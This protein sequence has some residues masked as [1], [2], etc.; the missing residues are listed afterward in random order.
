M[1]TAA[2]YASAD[3]Y[4]GRNLDLEY[5]YRETVTVTPRNYPFLFRSAASLNRH[6]A[7]IGMAFVV[8]EY[9][10][11]Y[12]ATN[13]KGL[14][15][16]GLNFPGNAHYGERRDGW[17]NIAPFEFI[18]WVLGQC[19]SL[20]EARR[21]LEQVNLVQIHFSEQ[22]PL[23][24]LHWMIADQR[25]AI[26]VEPMRDGLKV[27]DNPVG[28]LTNNPPFDYQMFNLNNYMQLTREPP[29]NRF[30]DGLE[31]TQYC[32]GM[33]AMGLPGDLSSASRFVRAAFTRMNSVSGPTESESVSQ[34]FHILGSVEQQ[35]GCSH[36]GGDK[37]EITVYSSCCNVD[38]GIYYYKTYENSQIAAVDMHRE[39]L[40]GEA[41][42]NY[43]LVEGQRFYFQN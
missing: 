36:L 17:D 26:V 21:L 39:N 38:R 24:P 34:F 5:S 40:D 12:D 43:P 7:M 18:P 8:D 4:F 23:A 35:R 32:S 10:L 14:S 2:T 20:D 16:A 33:G 9:P 22:L 19:A 6:Y 28:V 3:H 25:G 41:I 15:M 42:V 29:V 1:C 37:Y 13:E 31:L 27:Y 30:A 11:Y